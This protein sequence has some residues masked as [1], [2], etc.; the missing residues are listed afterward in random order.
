M[1]GVESHDR[2]F[3]K[4]PSGIWLPECGYFPGVEEYLRNNGIKYFIS[5]AHGM[6]YAEDRPVY[7]VYAPIRCPN[8]VALLPGTAL[9]QEQSGLQL[10]V[11][12]VILF[13]G[14]STGI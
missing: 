1:T 11:T 10:M 14:I 12:P 5:S 6:L 8:G 13:T 4:M 7:G 2:I 3:S 9:R